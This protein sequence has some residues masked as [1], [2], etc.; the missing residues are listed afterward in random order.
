MNPLVKVKD[1]FQNHLLPEKEYEA[2][3]EKNLVPL[4]IKI[5]VEDFLQEIRIHLGKKIS[6]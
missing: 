4:N 6:H 1:A 5:N 3:H 2:L